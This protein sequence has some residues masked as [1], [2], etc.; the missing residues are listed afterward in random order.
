MEDGRNRARRSPARP[1]GGR[2]VGPNGTRADREESAEEILARHGLVDPGPPARPPGGRAARRRAAEEKE[3]AAHEQARPRRRREP[4]PVAQGPTDYA[5]PPGGPP[6]RPG[7]RGH[8][9]TGQHTPIPGTAGRP[10]GTAPAPRWNGPPVPPPE[11]SRPRRAPARPDESEGDAPVAAVPPPVRRART[12]VDRPATGTRPAAGSAPAVDGPPDPVHVVPA[13]TRPPAEP[14]PDPDPE[15]DAA[16]ATRLRTQQID[17]TLT[18]LTAAHAGLA[19]PSR[20]GAAADADDADTDDAEPPASRPRRRPALGKL[21][22]A[23]VAVLIFVTTTFG[24]AAKVWL[25]S[26]VRE[27]DVLY[28]ESGSAIVDAAAQEGDE[29]VLV[30]GSD[31]DAPGGAAGRADTVVVAHVPAD[32]EGVVVV[33]FPSDLEIN[34]PPCERWDAASASYR[35]EIVPAE[36]RTPLRTAYDIGGPRCVVRVVQQLSGIAVTTFVGASLAGL[37]TMVEAVAGVEVCVPRPVLDTVFG[38]V[39]PDAGTSTLDG[40]RA[41]DF[42]RAGAV[43]GDPFADYGRVERQQ[44]LLAALLDT[45]LSDTGLLD[46]GRLAALRPA[47]GQALV[48]DGADLD[49]VLALALS[50][51]RLDAEGVTFAAVPTVGE[52][53]SRGNIVLRD[54]DASALFAAVRTDSPL[55]AQATDPR[56]A[57]RGSAPADLAVEV[58]NASDRSGLAGRVGETLS[59]VGFGVG[60]VGDAEQPTAQT[61][62]RFSPDQA[63]AAAILATAVPSAVS[64]PDPDPG[65]NGVLKLVLGRSFDDVVRAPAEPAG[66]AAAPT[67]ANRSTAAC[68]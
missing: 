50:L 14:A 62:I 38:P 46:I 42:V 13:D 34:R 8:D 35:D 36:A 4:P 18:R 48:T 32:G 51:R 17:E 22:V 15:S 41:R 16:A 40:M 53:N 6:A 64:V 23:A 58:L 11:T 57:G 10:G 7:D 2:D 1:P 37:A 68:G 31:V 45:A 56:A 9:G 27:V 59:S 60:M 55:P 47:L 28:P 44:Q 26:A 63:A 3:R 12:G 33:S 24:W 25:D 43:R 67:A 61:S 19:L 52:V 29:N 66:P 39:V 54:T 49:E 5:R 21:L 65:A 30:V 20:A